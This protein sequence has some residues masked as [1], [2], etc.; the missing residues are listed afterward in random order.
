MSFWCAAIKQ[1]VGMDRR[2]NT[3]AILESALS[4]RQFLG[5]LFWF[6]IRILRLDGLSWRVW[7]VFPGMVFA[8]TSVCLERMSGYQLRRI[9]GIN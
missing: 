4:V 1:Q 6:F 3:E 8:F 7:R 9:F 2:P 5:C